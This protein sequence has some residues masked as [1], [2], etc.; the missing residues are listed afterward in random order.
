LYAVRF[1]RVVPP[2]PWLMVWSFACVS[3]AGA[4]ALAYDT[5]RAAPAV[6]PILVLQ[7]FAVSAGFVASARRGYYDVLLTSGTGRAHA[8]LVH[9][10]MSAIP[11]AVSWVALGIAEAFIT[12]NARGVM[13]SG[14]VAAMFVVSTIPWAATVALPRFTGAIGWMLLCVMA[15]T[16]TPIDDQGSVF[17]YGSMREG[18]WS[19]AC[20]FLLFPMRLAGEDVFYRPGMVAPAIIVAGT[21]MAVALA[22]IHWTDLPLE[23]AQ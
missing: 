9:W 4:V 15:V 16:L 22:W 17:R 20:A 5:G 11:G 13:A 1:F 18:V 8:A 6:I 19:A 12:G 7:V 10:S 2:V 3:V 14:T 23:A 21:S